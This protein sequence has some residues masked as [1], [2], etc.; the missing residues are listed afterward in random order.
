MLPRRYWP[1]F[2]PSVPASQAAAVASV[3]TMSAGIALGFFGFFA[4]L[5][6]VASLNNAA[7]LEAA[8]RY[9]GEKLALPSALSGL[10]FFT[11]VLLTPQGWLSTY[12]TISGL[13]RAIGSQFDDPHGDFL[14]TLADEG[15]RRMTTA[16]VRRGEVA[17]RHLLEG[18]RVKDRVVRGSQVGLAASD[19]VIIASRTKEDWLPGTVVLSNRGEFRIQEFEDRTIDGHLRRLYSLSRVSDLEAFRRTVTYEF[20]EYVAPDIVVPGEVTQ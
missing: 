13:I 20:P 1:S 2:E 11:F 18:P 12:L 17:N 15:A 4:H 6:E 16:T 19:V 5:G 8:V 10:S 9:D 14:L 3:L 7:Y